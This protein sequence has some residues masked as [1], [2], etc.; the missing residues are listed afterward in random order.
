MI[1]GDA[2]DHT[3]NVLR[4][5]DSGAIQGNHLCD[6][7]IQGNAPEEEREGP[8]CTAAGALFSRVVVS[9]LG[10]AHSSSSCSASTSAS[11]AWGV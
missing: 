8:G 2:D 6:P 10:F 7:G 9:S 11:W 4:T 1:G 5:A 3:L